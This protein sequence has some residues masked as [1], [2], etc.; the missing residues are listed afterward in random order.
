MPPSTSSL[1]CG[2]VVPIPT[3]PPLKTLTFSVLFVL[4]LKSIASVV[5][6]KLVAATVLAFP[7]SDQAFNA[8]SAPVEPVLSVDPV[9]LVLPVEPVV[10]VLLVLP[11]EPVAPVLL[12]EPVEPVVPVLLV[13]PVEPVV[14]VL[15]VEPVEPVAPVIPKFPVHIGNPFASN[16]ITYPVVNGT[17]SYVDVRTISISGV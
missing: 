10:P 2:A 15:L 8:P 3:L 6:M 5:P 4:I 16:P 17:E 11:V 1:L 14:P 7:A 12:V 13:L 9:L